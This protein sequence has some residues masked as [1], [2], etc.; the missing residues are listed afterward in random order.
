MTTQEGKLSHSVD[1]DGRPRS[2]FIA[3]GPAIEHPDQVLSNQTFGT[4][5]IDT[6]QRSEKAKRVTYPDFL[7]NNYVYARGGANRTTKDSKLLG[8]RY[9]AYLPLADGGYA[10]LEY[11]DPKSLLEETEWPDDL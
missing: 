2:N 5:Q 3:T 6:L 1:N 9:R 11:A 4:F 8:I 7:Y 10:M